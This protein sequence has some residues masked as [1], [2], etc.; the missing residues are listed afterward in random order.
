MEQGKVCDGRRGEVGKGSYRATAG[1]GDEGTEQRSLGGGWV[2]ENTRMKGGGGY[3]EMVQRRRFKIVQGGR[4]IY[5]H[6][7]ML[8]HMWPM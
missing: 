1:P 8:L 2:E 5:I 3:D 7:G 6:G 4:N